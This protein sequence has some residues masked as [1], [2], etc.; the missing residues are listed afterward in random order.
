M[1]HALANE[2]WKSLLPDSAAWLDQVK[3]QAGPA[4]TAG[5]HHVVAVKGDENDKTAFVLDAP[6]VPAGTAAK[7]LDAA[8]ALGW[9]PSAGALHVQLGGEGGFA[10]TLVPL[11]TTKVGRRQIG[12]QLGLDAAKAVKELKINHLVLCEAAGATALDVFDGYAGGLYGAGGFK[13]TR[14]PDPKRF[15][16]EVTLGGSDAKADELKEALEMARS[17]AFVRFLQDAPANWLDPIKLAEIAKDMAREVGAQCKILDKEKMTQLGMGSFLSVNDGSAVEPRT[18]VIEVEGHDNSKCVALVGKGLTF[19]SGGIS[20]KPAA[21]MEE[22]KYDM[23][24]GAAVLGAARFFAKVKPPTKVAFVIG[25][26][27]NLISGSATKPGDVVRAMNGKTIE[28][29]NT[30]AEG[31]LVLADCLHYAITEFKPQ[32]VVDIATLTGAVLVA[33]GCV[34]AG[35]LGNDDDAVQRVLKAGEAMGEPLWR[36]P[37]WPELEKETK[38]EVADLKNIAKGS[39]KG[40]TIMGGMFLKEFVGDAKWVHLDIAGTG[41]NCQATGF[42][43]S[44]GSAFGM[45]TMIKACQSYRE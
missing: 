30:D 35:V 6:K 7:I 10:A 25:A 43:G 32:L 9:K 8:K 33:L 38:G 27:E 37:L 26:T 44:G 14:K 41:W 22:M 18:I 34:G 20:I 45:R 31:R 39:V 42:P 5:A 3:L 40:G 17:A 11:N 29:H 1:R 4:T 36:L 13:G 23:S 21:G 2:P 19:D 15:P 12:R 16:A 28:V 24:G